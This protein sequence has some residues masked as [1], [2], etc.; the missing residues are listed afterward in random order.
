MNFPR[1]FATAALAFATSFASAQSL[2]ASAQ[3]K[4]E[5][6]VKL[7]QT[8]AADPLIVSAVKAHNTSLPAD[9]AAMTQDK[10]K[11]LSILDP[12]VRSFTKNPA[13][14]LIKS[15]KSPLISEAFLS[16]ADGLKISFL[17]K[18]SGFS[19]KGKAKH[20]E[21]MAGKIWHGEIELDESTGSQQI[22]FAVPVLDGD[23]PIGSLVMGVAVSKLKD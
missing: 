10:W 3:A 1:L 7:A 8:L 4:L 14:E 16:G 23:K 17:T 21:P 6:Q 9:S 13:A 5:A 22:Q 2:D 15:R 12:A 19:H 20:E 18:P 11:S